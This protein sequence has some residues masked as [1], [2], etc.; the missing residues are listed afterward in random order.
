MSAYKRLHYSPFDFLI[1]ISGVLCIAYGAFLFNNTGHLSDQLRES[2]RFGTIIDGQGTRKLNNSL[3]WFDVEKNNSLFYGDVIFANED[4]P[5]EIGILNEE[6]NLVVPKDSMIKI[7]KLGDEFNLDVS[8]GSIVIKTKGTKKVKLNLKDKRGKIRKLTISK[9]SDIKISTRKS[10]VTVE[11][12]KGEASLIKIDAKPTEK[13]VEIKKDKIFVIGRKK[14]EILQKEDIV[15]VNSSDPLLESALPVSNKYKSAKFLEVSK[16]NKFTSA[17]K[18]PI[19]DGH[20][21]ISRFGYGL[22][23]VRG[24][25]KEKLDSFE[26]GL[27]KPM[28]IN[29]S[30]K[31]SYYPGDKLK[32][33]WSGRKDLTYKI[34]IDG[35]EKVEK[36]LKQNYYIYTVDS[37]NEIRIKVEDQRFKRE[38][39]KILSFQ[40]SKLLEIVDIKEIQV[41]NNVFRNLILKNPRKINYR[42]KVLDKEGKVL[43]DRKSDTETFLMKVSK[44]GAYDLKITQDET[45]INLI[46][47][48]FVIKDRITN[49]GKNKIFY[50]TG[51]NLEAKLQWKRGGN[52]PKD[53]E[54]VIKIF[55]SN[56]KKEP[57]IEKKTLKTNYVYETKKEEKFFWKIESTIPELIDSSALFETEVAR[58]KFPKLESPK[59]L[60]KYD[61]NKKCYLF[62]VPK[63]KYVNSYDIYIFSSRS[64]V[65]QNRK[66]MYHR[67]LNT[68]TDCLPAK[69]LLVFE[70]KYYYKYRIIDRWK[71]TSPYSQI[72]LMFFPISPL[73]RY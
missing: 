54:Y 49:A 26:L 68:N 34:T 45:K 41:K 50:S 19:V 14:A 35:S 55:K 46:D 13:P 33:T 73:D 9:N 66:A 1:I 22:Y 21:D 47:T 52:V 40:L 5:I 37:D 62:S 43:V 59:V 23:Y 3:Q 48:N 8:K 60:F 69:D 42:I 10:N 16:N 72:G 11:A 7:T 61:K 38:S 6:S 17:K 29:I 44:P 36:V 18:I 57:F 4:Q 70:G 58:P 25:D 27:K 67:L 63:V 64:K 31:D 28:R 2:E 65:D 24:N 12:V 20:L 51:K 32:I 71:R 39:K 56:N 15:T 53:M 30:K